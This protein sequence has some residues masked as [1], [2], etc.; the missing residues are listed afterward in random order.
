MSMPIS[1]MA[2]TASGLSPR[3]S[4]P[5]LSTSNRPAP[6]SRRN[7]SA[8]CERAELCVQRNRTRLASGI[9]IGLPRAVGRELAHHTGDLVH[10]A[11]ADVL[12]AVAHALEVVRHP[13]QPRGAVDRRRVV[14]HVL[15]ELAVDDVVQALSLIHI[16]EPTRLLS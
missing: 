9:G 12:D 7:A 5:A 8:I 3:A 2:W 14:R 10:R 16:S 15:E 13:Q 11:L 1:A 6:S 4:V